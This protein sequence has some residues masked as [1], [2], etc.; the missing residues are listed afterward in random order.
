MANPGGVSDQLVSLVLEAVNRGLAL[1]AT[2]RALTPFMISS[3]DV[4]TVLATDTVDEAFAVVQRT[5]A[6]GEVD[7]CVFICDSYL[8]MGGAR[9]DAL[10]VEAYQRGQPTP[11]RF[12]QRYRNPAA[13]LR[14]KRRRLE[15]IGDV[16]FL[17]GKGVVHIPQQESGNGTS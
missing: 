1:R 2:G 16:L 9:T 14:R 7:Y 6:S 10:M 3:D 13:G 4:L 8:D 12:A 11:L 15:P 17:S 5:M